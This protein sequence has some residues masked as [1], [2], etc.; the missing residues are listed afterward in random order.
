MVVT[1]LR[2]RRAGLVMCRQPSNLVLSLVLPVSHKWTM[3][4]GRF[5]LYYQDD[6]WHLP[7]VVL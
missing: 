5:L 4:R 6:L 2:V 3:T 1:G 7:L